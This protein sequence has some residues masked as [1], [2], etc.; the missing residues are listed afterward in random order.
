MVICA[1]GDLGAAGRD[2]E[3]KMIDIPAYK[4]ASGKEVWNL[5]TKLT[6]NFFRSDSSLKTGLTNTN[7]ETPKSGSV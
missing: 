5:K 7:S 2:L 6:I 4:P 3:G 1:W